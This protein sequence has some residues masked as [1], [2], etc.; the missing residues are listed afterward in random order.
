MSRP[1]AAA[2][3]LVLSAG[4]TLVAV[5]TVA[6]DAAPVPAGHLTAT[7]FAA[8]TSP[9]APAV[10]SSPG[11]GPTAPALPIPAD[12]T[13]PATP[14]VATPQLAASRPAEPPEPPE[15][16]SVTV[17]IDGLSPLVLTPEADLRLTLTLTNTGD[18]PA[19]PRVVVHLGTEFISRTSLDVWRTAAADDPLG[20]MVHAV[21]LPS[22]APGASTTASL[23]VPA[24]G[25]GLTGTEW[26]ARG[27]AVEVVD[28]EVL[29]GVARTFAVWFPQE[30]PTTRVT[31]AVPVTGPPQ[32]PYRRFATTRALE[33]LTAPEGRLTALAEAVE[34][35]PVT[36]VADPALLEAARSRGGT[37]AE[38]VDRLLGAGHELLVLPWGDADL[39]ALAAAERTD[40]VAAAVTRAEEG[41]PDDARFRVAWPAEPLPDLT[42]VATA[43][44]A[45]AAG[46][47]VGLD[48][49]TPPAVLTY[50]PSSR[51]TVSA[52]GTDVSVLVPDPRLSRALMTGQVGSADGAGTAPG[53]E[54]TPAVAGQDLLAELAV[55]TRERPAIERHLL[56]TVPRD[57]SPDPAVAAAQLAALAE[58]PWVEL[59]GMS[60][61]L[62]T[63]DPQVDRGRLP[64]T[65]AV[66]GLVSG[67]DL[68][69]AHAGMLDRDALARMLA[70]PT[71]V[72]G[73][74]E[75]EL[76]ALS[77]QG[78]RSDPGVRALALRTATGTAHRLRGGVHVEES[79]TINLISESGELPVRV[80][81]RLDQ[82]VT[83]VVE[84]DPE[85]ARLVADEPIPVTVPARDSVLVQV[86]LHAVGSGDVAVRIVLTT[87]EGHP[88]DADTVFTVRVRAEW[89]NIGTAV[90]G[91]LLALG[92]LTSIIRTAR[93]GRAASRADRI[94]EAGPEGEA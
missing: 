25:L 50:T 93:R 14:D 51:V 87:P 54:V 88:V 20:P 44:A 68:A 64:V 81:N 46:V 4:L 37:A 13:D 78:W 79:S 61:L 49:L 36:L 31:V 55:I 57:W 52:G 33:Q 6:D 62:R 70:D 28:G 86:P 3:A 23:T 75:T 83:V 77:S 7:P 24:A 35:T 9:L 91:G 63:E 72:V 66:D 74:P 60:E 18:R 73:D 15:P 40:L 84:L 92:L 85:E 17:A 26:G 5:P 12:P 11:G 53:T 22:L 1:L 41:A 69:T 59:T 47:V 45:G 67:D 34:A 10:T 56:L 38:W 30:A 58:A 82:E 29:L 80:A 94:A 27:L 48:V 71:T 90:I 65:T 39:T 76:L 21:E 32:N 8:D 19:T 16:G 42:T 89:E 43:R 2:G